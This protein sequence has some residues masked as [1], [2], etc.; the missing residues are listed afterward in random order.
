[1][2]DEITFRPP[3]RVPGEQGYIRNYEKPYVTGSITVDINKFP[4]E[5]LQEIMDSRGRLMLQIDIPRVWCSGGIAM[6]C[7][8]DGT[9]VELDFSAN[10]ITI[11]PAK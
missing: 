2:S 9:T 1:M 8:Y 11:A 4:L 3:M 7:D 6:N 10:D 5:L